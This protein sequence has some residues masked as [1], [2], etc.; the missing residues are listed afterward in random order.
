MAGA[1]PRQHATDTPTAPLQPPTVAEVFVALLN[2][3]V[4]HAD[5]DR[6]GASRGGPGGVCS[7][8]RHPPQ[9]AQL[10]I[11]GEPAA[12]LSAVDVQRLGILHSCGSTGGWAV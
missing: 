9:A 2:P 10:R 4:H 7:D 6:P 1:M 12:L 5:L 3:G 8:G 11:V